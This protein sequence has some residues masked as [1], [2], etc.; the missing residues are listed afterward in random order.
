MSTTPTPHHLHLPT[1]FTLD[2]RPAAPG[3]KGFVIEGG[4]KVVRQ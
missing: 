4:N 3:Q 1:A 2:G